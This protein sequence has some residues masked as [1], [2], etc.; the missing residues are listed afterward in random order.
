M[1]ERINKFLV[2]VEKFMTEMHLRQ[3]GFTYSICG[4]FTKNKGKLQKIQRNK[5]GSIYLSK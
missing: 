3:P 2:A 1:N 5:R 4:L